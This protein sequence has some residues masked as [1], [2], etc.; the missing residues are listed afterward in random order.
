[1]RH[2]GFST[3]ALALAD[4]RTALKILA[5]LP[6]DAV[7][8]SALREHELF[9]LLDSFDDLDLR[10]FRYVSIHAPSQMSREFEAAAADRLAGFAA[11]GLPIIVHPDAISD[12][13]LWIPMGRMLC[14]E[15][16]DKRKPIGR[17]ADELERI[18]KRVPTPS[19]LT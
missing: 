12:W 18:F 13:D 17:T 15:N 1:M 14:I 4:F 9:P 3:G 7:E 11:G 10:Q 6:L 19:V 8:L 16:M 2:I 5:M